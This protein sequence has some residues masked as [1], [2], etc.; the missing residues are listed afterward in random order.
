M[1]LNF[2]SNFQIV[3]NKIIGK[4]MNL[5]YNLNLIK[6]DLYFIGNNKLL[7][8]FTNQISCDEIGFINE[9]NLFIPEYILYYTKNNVEVLKLNT[10]IKN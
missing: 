5:E 1:K 6:A 3:T 9:Q 7:L 4:L 8:S 10:F 2:F